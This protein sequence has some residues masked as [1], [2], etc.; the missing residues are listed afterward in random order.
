ML[1]EKG[2]NKTGGIIVLV[3]DGKNSPGYLS[4]SD[5]QK[6]IIRANIRVI[7]IAIGCMS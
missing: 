7:T 1:Q 6:D 5:V 2:N 4:I 3:T